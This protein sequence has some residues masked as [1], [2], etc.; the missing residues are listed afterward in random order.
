MKNPFKMN[1]EINQ[2]KVLNSSMRH[3]LV[4]L[5]TMSLVYIIPGAAKAPAKSQSGQFVAPAKFWHSRP[6]P[7]PTPGRLWIMTAPCQSTLNRSVSIWHV[8]DRLYLY[9]TR[10]SFSMQCDTN[11][12]QVTL[13]N[14]IAEGREIFTWSSYLS[15]LPQSLSLNN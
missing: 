10:C 4:Q 3:W 2:T 15:I 8:L 1:N 14:K 9:E 6:L 11:I 5:Q 12:H 13:Q 7:N